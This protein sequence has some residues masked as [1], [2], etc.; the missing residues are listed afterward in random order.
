MFK[1]LLSGIGIVALA[2][3]GLAGG[4]SANAVKNPCLIKDVGSNWVI[5]E[6]GY[7]YTWTGSAG[8]LV[9][10][11][12]NL[13]NIVSISGD[14]FRNFSLVE[15]GSVYYYAYDIPNPVEIKI[16]NV[17]KFSVVNMGS[18]G[19]GVLVSEDGTAYVVR[20]NNDGG[21]ED[22]AKVK[23]VSNVVEAQFDELGGF[24]LDSSGKG[25][26]IFYRSYWVGSENDVLVRPLPEKLGTIKDYDWYNYGEQGLVVNTAGK[27]FFAEYS[28][29][30]KSFTT[31]PISGLGHLNVKSVQY[32]HSGS[33]NTAFAVTDN[34]RVFH[35]VFEYYESEGVKEIKELT[36]LG[37][38][39]QIASYNNNAL[40]LKEDGEVLW[41]NEDLEATVV[42]G[43]GTVKQL[44]H[45]SVLNTE[46]EAFNVT[47]FN[48]NF[49]VYPIQTGCVPPTDPK[50]VPVE[51]SPV[52]PSTT[53]A[54]CSF[55]N[56]GRYAFPTLNIPSNS[57]RVSYSVEGVSETGD[58]LNGVVVATAGENA[59][60]KE[61]LPEGWVKENS[62]RA[63]WEY[64]LNGKYCEEREAVEL[65]DPVIVQASCATDGSI[66]NPVITLP[67]TSGISYTMEGVVENG[68]TLIFTATALEGYK[69]VES[70]GWVVNLEG[71]KATMEITLDTVECESEKP[72]GENGE[73]PGG[74]NGEKPGGEDGGN[75]PGS[76]TDK[77]GTT[78]PTERPKPS[79]PSG[80]T[81]GKTHQKP[82]SSK[83]I[84]DTPK[85]GGTVLGLGLLGGSIIAGI[86]TLIARRNW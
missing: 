83:D 3:V 29:Y 70:E 23:G 37:K 33:E 71:T 8:N 39:S 49:S 34:G 27:V 79:G 46:G 67:K 42:Q 12:R 1:K 5:D 65:E 21:L 2:T 60:F 30:Y 80:S 25:Y 62:T 74:E 84:S 26:S 52:T 43:V 9:D 75:K 40:V 59:V 14:G 56:E 47:G 24:L 86:G 63:L 68:E 4:E 82:A 54:E 64:S 58:T 17:D 69:L 19:Q 28:D 32:N 73:T 51:V 10:P 7:G 44:S 76:G 77:P 61:N 22:F 72:G 15:D 20:I 31:Y 78:K 35:L 50:P 36:G 18:Q 38:V 81:D 11:I 85:S 66:V 45:E 6:R 48:D 41:L 16:P 57:D 13:D 55:E 53:P